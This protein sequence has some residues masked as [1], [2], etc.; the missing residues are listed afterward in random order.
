MTKAIGTALVVD[1][2]RLARTALAKLLKKHGIE[3][4]VAESGGGAVDYIAT[5]EPP[6]IVF[7]DYTM[8]DIDGFQAVERIRE[9]F[10]DVAPIAMYT[11]QDGDAERARAEELGI[12]AFLTKPA[13]EERLDAVLDK[14]TAAVAARKATVDEPAGAAAAPGKPADAARPGADE[15]TMAGAAEPEDAPATDAQATTSAKPAEPSEVS[16]TDALEENVAAPATL[17]EDS[18]L[19]ED[20]IADEPGGPDTEADAG[21][22]TEKAASEATA[23]PNGDASAAS[24][25]AGH[26]TAEETARSVAE[27][28][29]RAV[30]D[31]AIREATET[32]AA[33]ASPPAAKQAM[34]EIRKDMATEVDRI[35]QSQAATKRIAQVF[36]RVAWPKL[37]EHVVTEV[38]DGVRGEMQR[39]AREAAAEDNDQ[40]TDER[41]AET[42]HLIDERTANLRSELQKDLSE[43]IEEVENRLQRLVIAVCAGLGAVMVGG[44]VIVLWVG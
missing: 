25:T 14:L 34:A 32:I 13:N 18:R 28:K 9:Q 43:R 17:V 30:A 22:P 35:L 33:A 3:I 4:E 37:R 27:A 40:A 39:I 21:A 10:G 12:T 16:A 19:D 5:N 31:H 11:G 2:S 6:D 8:P 29:A 23:T 26:G 20:V 42:K 41:S 7:M 38:T 44:F 15:P 24:E 36:L 1:D